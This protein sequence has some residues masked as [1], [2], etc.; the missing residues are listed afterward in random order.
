MFYKTKNIRIK[1]NGAI[2]LTVADSSIRPLTYFTTEYKGTV[3]NLLKDIYEGNFHLGYS[4]SNTV[5]RSIMNA[6]N[7]IVDNAINKAGL[8]WEDAYYYKIPQRDQ[9]IS[10]ICDAYAVRI[11][12]NDFS[13]GKAFGEALG[14]KIEPVISEGLKLL[15]DTKKNDAQ[16]GVYRISCAAQSIFSK[17][18]V[19]YDLLQPYG[20]DDFMLAPSTDYKNGVLRT[21]NSKIVSLG[22][23]S[24]NLYP[25]LSF[26]GINLTKK[27]LIDLKPEK[28]EVIDLVDKIVGSVLGAGF[29]LNAKPYADF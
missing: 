10:M 18:E 12:K 7:Y 29:T 8:T 26:S 15:A 17:D 11:E 25:F 1:K 19:V 5:Y 20:E 14:T 28:K 24:G 21:D 6:I 4:K 22:K 23:N 3:G 27:A 16:N 9:A 2:S 13:N